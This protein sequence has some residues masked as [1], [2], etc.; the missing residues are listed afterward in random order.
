M[1]SKGLTGITTVMIYIGTLLLSILSFFTTLAG[2]RILLDNQLAVIGS[3]GLQ[4]AMLGIAWNLLKIKE[5]RVTYVSV[6][7]VA[8]AFSIFFSYANFDSNLKSPTR[9]NNARQQYAQSARPILSEY[10]QT[11]REAV[12]N[13]RYQVERLQNILALEE[14]K[15]W[16]TVCDEGSGDPFIQSVIDGAR[17]TV[18]SWKARNGT[19][20]GQGSGRGIIVS[21]LESQLGQAQQNL[22]STNGYLSKLDSLSLAFNS[23]LTVESQHD[24]INQAWVSFPSGEVTRLLYR[25]PELSLPPSR[26]EFVEKPTTRQQAFMLVIHDLVAMDE[27]ALFSLLLALAIDLIVILMAFAG[28]YIVND[29]DYLFDRVRQNTAGRIRKMHL[30]DQETVKAV[31]DNN[32]EMYRGAGKY[33]LEMMRVLGDYQN[34]KKKFRIVLKREGEKITREETRPDMWDAR[35]HSAGATDEQRL[36]IKNRMESQ[37]SKHEQD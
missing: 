34:Q 13:G 30:D 37:L 8:A 22:Q 28:S 3:L 26:A 33:G 14:E 25:T 19:D 6:F 5:N 1:L 16:A 27:L 24:L 9:V 23:F 21:Y 35:N 29:I 36:G 11:A 18:D 12:V 4:I 31:L 10:A 32:L 7:S 17:R 20:Y 2:M 15:G